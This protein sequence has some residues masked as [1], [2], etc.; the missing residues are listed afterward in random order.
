MHDT[1][2]WNRKVMKFQS[3]EKK[4]FF[5]KLIYISW[6]PRQG[7]AHLEKKKNYYAVY[8]KSLYCKNALCI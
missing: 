7:M 8:C 4:D 2:L 1:L 3:S 5:H 6:L